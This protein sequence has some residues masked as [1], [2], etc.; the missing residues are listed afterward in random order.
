[1][2]RPQP[3][4]VLPATLYLNY[5]VNAHFPQPTPHFYTSQFATSTPRVLAIPSPHTR[6]FIRSPSS[7]SAGLRSSPSRSRSSVLLT[8]SPHSVRSLSLHAILVNLTRPLRCSRTVS[9]ASSPC[10]GH[11]TSSGYCSCRHQQSERAGGQRLMSDDFESA[12][13]DR[14]RAALCVRRKQSSSGRA[15][16]AVNQPTQRGFSWSVTL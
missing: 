2:S 12:H 1:V 4:P 8:H 5:P 11:C 3:A 10:S 15:S 9:S 16:F 6:V 13:G 14:V 7:R